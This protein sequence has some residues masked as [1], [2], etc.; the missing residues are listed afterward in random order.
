MAAVILTS[1][2]TAGLREREIAK[3]VHYDEVEPGDEVGEP[4]LFSI[5]CFRLKPI[6]E[7][8]DV[9]EAPT[10]KTARHRPG[11]PE[12]IPRSRS[13]AWENRRETRP[14]PSKNGWIH[15]SR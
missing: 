13:N 1:P 10:G 8:D 3:L 4:A 14:L 11:S 15:A 2:N 7:I 5:A 12:P 9:V 6:V